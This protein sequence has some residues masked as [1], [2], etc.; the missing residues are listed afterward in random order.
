[1]LLVVCCTVLLW[2]GAPARATARNLQTLTITSAAVGPTQVNVL[3]PADY[4]TSTRRY[5]VLYLLHGY[6]GSSTD[7]VRYTDITRLVRTLPLIVVMP[8]AAGGWYMNP[9]IPGPNWE[10][11]HI[12]E[13][14]PYVDAHYRTIANRGGRAIAGLSMGGMGAVSYAARH[15]DLFVAAAS[16]SGVLDP[17][18]FYPLSSGQVYAPAA[19]FGSLCGDWVWCVRAHS[20][21][22][23]ASNLRGQA[24][25]LSAGNGKPG[26]LDGSTSTPDAREVE[27]QVHASLVTMVHALQTAGIP[28]VVDD[29]GNGTHIWPYWQRELHRAL[30]VLLATLAKPPSPPTT[31]SYVWADAA[32]RVWGYTLTVARAGGGGGYTRLTHVG[33][34]GFSVTGTGRVSVV[35]APIYAGNHPYLVGIGAGRPARLRADSQGRLHLVIQLG[36]KPATVPVTLVAAQR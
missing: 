8:D 22:D 18:H 6:G 9:T 21:V 25:F 36:S 19:V 30:P 4:T 32:E 11:Y 2:S 7:W 5:P 31:W 17:E 1:V 23:L 27:A 28:A 3:L 10:T 12:H 33:P 13:L 14:I 29:Y 16:F 15:P 20:P 24:L 34:H 26:P 35:T